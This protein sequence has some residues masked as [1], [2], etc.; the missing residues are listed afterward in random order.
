MVFPPLCTAASA[1]VA[2]LSAGLSEEEV[3]LITEEDGYVLKFKAVAWWQQL[4]RK[5]S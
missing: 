5:F 2:A 1:E 3:G 4:R